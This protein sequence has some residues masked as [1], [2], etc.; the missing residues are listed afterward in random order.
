MIL[1]MRGN[2]Y[3][4][5]KKHSIKE[6]CLL[7]KIFPRYYCI[8]WYLAFKFDKYRKVPS[9]IYGELF[10]WAHHGLNVAACA[11]TGQPVM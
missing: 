9:Q 3:G 4:L 10:K 1:T 7:K 2:I 8:A 6:F 11:L 5:S